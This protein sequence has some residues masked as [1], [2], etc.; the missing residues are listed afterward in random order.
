MATAPA[1]AWE[2]L[3][4]LEELAS[5]QAGERSGKKDRP[6]ATVIDWALVADWYDRC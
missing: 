3:A 2:R 6:A 1:A 4:W 5:R